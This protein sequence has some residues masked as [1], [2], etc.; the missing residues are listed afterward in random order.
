MVKDVP[1]RAYER[2]STGHND[3]ITQSDFF[4]VYQSLQLVPLVGDG[5]SCQFEAVADAACGHIKSAGQLRKLAVARIGDKWDEIAE[6]V[7]NEVAA[8]T[9]VSVSAL[10][11]QQCLD[12]MSGCGNS[13]GIWGNHCTLVQRSPHCQKNIVVLCLSEGQAY[14]H[15][16]QSEDCAETIH[17]GFVP[18]VHYFPVK[19]KLSK[20]D[21]GDIS[22]K[23]IRCDTYFSPRT[24]WPSLQKPR[25]FAS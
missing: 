15:V 20:G 3:R 6:F 2:T 11:K 1:D 5:H 10:D 19:K 17:I 25:S 12:L 9:C 16:L 18:E 7:L 24:V 22:H 4:E 23:F 14:K 21:K 8:Q 13:P